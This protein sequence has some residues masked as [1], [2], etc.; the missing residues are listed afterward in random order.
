[1]VNP[2]SY[3]LGRARA[4]LIPTNTNNK[5]EGTMSE[6]EDFGFVPAM[7]DGDSSGEAKEAEEGLAL[8]AAPRDLES[9]KADNEAEEED[10][11]DDEQKDNVDDDEKD[12]EAAGSLP[13]ELTDPKVLEFL[14]ILD[15]YRV[16]CED[17]GNYAEAERASDQL[18]NL[19]AQEMKRQVKAM[20]AR[21]ISERQDIQL[22]HQVQF[23][24]FNTSWDRYLD[25]FDN[26]AQGYIRTMTA[27]HA[28]ELRDFQEQLH[29]SVVAKPPKFSKE[30]LEWR[31]RQH[32]LAK[33]A[34]YAE[35]Q[36]I[37][38]IADMMEKKE[39]SRMDHSADSSFA[40][41]EGKFRSRQQAELNALLKRI[42][43]RRKEHLGQRNLDSKRLLQRNKNV[44][45]VLVSKQSVEERAARQDIK[46][47]LSRPRTGIFGSEPP[48]KTPQQRP[49]RTVKKK[50]TKPKRRI[51]D[52]KASPLPSLSSSSSPNSAFLT[53]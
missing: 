12:S 8:V 5:V 13:N 28:Q 31:R 44:Q 48:K 49:K 26:M 36:K 2:F 30:L 18:D 3:I 22:A 53:S 9:K 40:A 43:V 37:K 24:E 16:K 25:E 45:A 29:K 6:S 38:K 39:R 34:Q 10:D 42:D 11:D 32:M 50:A 23:K 1:M 7:L 21:Q 17:E 19:R 20:K 52:K 27:K 41:K 46:D 15:E 35:A 14:R 51:E 33:S 47:R 4:A